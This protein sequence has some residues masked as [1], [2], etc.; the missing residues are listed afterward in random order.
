MT[1][2]I[3]FIKEGNKKKMLVNVLLDESGS[4]GLCKETTISGINEYI[5]SLQATQKREGGE[6]LFSLTKF[7]SEKTDLMYIVRPINSI[8]KLTDKTYM[9][10]GGTPLYDALGQTIKKVVKELEGRVNK[11]KVLILIM[12]DGEENSSKEYT[13]EKIVEMIKE[14]EKDKWTFVY[15]GANQDSWSNAQQ[16]GLSKGNVANCSYATKDWYSPLLRATN[17]M[18]CSSATTT[19]SYFEDAKQ[20]K[21]EEK[22]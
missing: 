11:P 19:D 16:I 15:L 8:E 7:S 17:V 13:K 1:N 10:N 20:N 12:T 4:M 6:M 3:D 9:P 5:Q 18:Y 2:R 21:E 22:K 14:K